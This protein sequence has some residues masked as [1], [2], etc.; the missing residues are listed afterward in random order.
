MILG[1]ALFK[2]VHIDVFQLALGRVRK[3]KIST[4]LFPSYIA[5][6]DKA[7]HLEEE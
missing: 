2:N 4:N 1:F 5:A 6:Y 7:F 3:K